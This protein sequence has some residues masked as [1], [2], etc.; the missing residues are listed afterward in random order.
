MYKK[1]VFFNSTMEIG[2]P[3]RVISLWGTYFVNKGYDIEVVSNID[4]P[5]FY[6]FDKRIKYSVLGIGK[7]KQKTD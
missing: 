6:E 2:G 7:F 4:V 1:I 3:A 5:L